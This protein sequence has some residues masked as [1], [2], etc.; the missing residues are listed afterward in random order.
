MERSLNQLSKFG[1]SFV[2]ILGDLTH[3]GSPD[4]IEECQ[5]LLATSPVPVHLMIGNHDEDA[6]RFLQAFDLGPGYYYFDHADLHFV[7]LRTHPAR[8]LSAADQ[9]WTWLKTDLAAHADRDTFIFSHYSLIRHPYLY[10]IKDTKQEVEN[11][12]EICALR[13][14]HT[15]VR[16]AFAGH[17]NIPSRTDDGH[18]THLLCPRIVHYPC[19]FDVV[20]VYE[21]G[22][23]RQIFEI[24]DLGLM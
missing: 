16:A 3:E 20:D 23:V 2:V 10:R 7:C 13:R 21:G 4:Q 6:A 9:Q 8:D 24:D 15:K 19:G 5:R 18:V 1:A 12:A 14:S 11:P 17:K 22:L